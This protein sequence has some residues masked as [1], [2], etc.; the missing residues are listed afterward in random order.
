M[1][2]STVCYCVGQR[3]FLYRVL[4]ALTGLDLHIGK[5]FYFRGLSDV[6]EDSKW[7]Q[8]LGDTTGRC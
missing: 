7:L 8:V 2:K 4:A 5:L 3:E 1:P 6:V